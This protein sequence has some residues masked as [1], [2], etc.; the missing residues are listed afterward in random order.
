MAGQFL[1]I[2]FEKY[3]TNYYERLTN[4][5]KRNDQVVEINGLTIDT[6]SRRVFVN[7]K[8]IN[9][10]SKEFDILLLLIFLLSLIL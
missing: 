5:D 8:E 4:K 2:I 6:Y 7:D 1:Y 10:A 3:V 9:L